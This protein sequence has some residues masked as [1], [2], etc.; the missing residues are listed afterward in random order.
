M[1][2]SAYEDEREQSRRAGSQGNEFSFVADSGKDNNLSM[3]AAVNG[4]FDD[5]MAFNDANASMAELDEE[6]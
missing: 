4:D 6:W 3:V 5:S 2:V 1:P